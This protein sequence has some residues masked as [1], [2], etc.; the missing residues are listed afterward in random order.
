[1]E[2]RGIIIGILGFIL[3]VVIIVGLNCI[4]TV[5]TGYVGVKTRF[6]KVQ[7]DVIQEGFNT[8]AP[9]IEKIVKIDCKTKKIETATEGSTKDMQTVSTS[10]AV[11]Y[12]VNKETANKLYKEV[13][14]EYEEIIINPAIQESIKSSMAGYTAEEL[15]TKRAEVSNNIEKS[16]TEKISDK[17]FLVT[18]FNL[19]NIDFSEAY[20][21]AIEAKA[22]KQQEVETSKAELEKQKINNEREIQMAEKDA[23][24]ME[25]KNSQITENI[26]RLKNLEVQQSM[27]NKWNGGLPQTT[28]GQNIMSMFNLGQ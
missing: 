11:N 5:P 8:K 16:I 2:V 7:D 6:G 1:M 12:N 10:I 3:L 23:K 27:I 19:T 14:K 17:G 18:E 24:I 25:L 4:T 20:D 28:L 13:G 21:L 15:I 9:F 26:L 22:V